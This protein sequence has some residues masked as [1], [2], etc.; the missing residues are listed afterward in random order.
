MV[1]VK[2]DAIG[3]SHESRF[4]G[5]AVAVF[6]NGAIVRVPVGAEIGGIDWGEIAQDRCF[7]EAEDDPVVSSR[8]C[9]HEIEGGQSP[10]RIADLIALD[11]G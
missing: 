8:V 10:T 7:A 11:C 3:A 1:N 9:C 2:A 5:R 6:P 4:C